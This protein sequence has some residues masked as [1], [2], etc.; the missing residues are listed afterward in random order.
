[1]TQYPEAALA[2]ELEICFLGIALITDYDVGVEGVRASTGQEIIKVFQDNNERLRKLLW[3]LIP[4]VPEE[5]ACGCR[6]ALEG[7]QITASEF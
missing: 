4:G 5:R 1:M 2:R 3:R 7:A 6:N